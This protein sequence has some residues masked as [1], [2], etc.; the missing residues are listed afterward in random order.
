M[1]DQLVFQ[2]GD[3]VKTK[4]GRLGIA[5]KV[6]SRL[7]VLSKTGTLNLTDIIEVRRPLLPLS[8][9][10]ITGWNDA[11]IVWR[12]QPEN[13]TFLGVSYKANPANVNKVRSLFK[14]VV[15]YDESASLSHNNEMLKQA[16]NHVIVPPSDFSSDHIIG[17][18]LY[19][20]YLVRKNCGKTTAIYIGNIILPI[21]QVYKLQTS[22]M[23][24][25]ALVIY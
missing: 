12:K 21:K 9:V 10:T 23:T 18:G 25:S 24:K 7:W 17:E 19:Q 15:E 20:Q 14:N 13:I 1:N 22:D 4:D 5:V 11:T 2:P 16:T 8:A 6:F 3:L